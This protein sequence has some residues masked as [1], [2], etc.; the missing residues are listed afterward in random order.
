MTM[1]DTFLRGVFHTRLDDKNRVK[2]PKIL[3][4]I[5]RTQGRS[6]VVMLMPEPCLGV[7]SDREWTRIWNPRPSD[8]PL[9]APASLKGLEMS[10]ILGSRTWSFTLEPQGRI[11]ISDLCRDYAGL[12]LD[13]EVA[14][15]GTE[16]RIELW[17][18]EM[19][20]KHISTIAGDF[21]SMLEQS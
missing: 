9:F 4:D 2:V 3:V 21:K 5:I 16:N 6:C 20:E 11:T 13:R 8:T 15:V 7:Y 1:T 14:I 19:W 10:R 12:S 17:D 18:R